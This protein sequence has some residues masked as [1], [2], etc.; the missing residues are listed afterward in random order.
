VI[1]EHVGP[2]VSTPVTAW[3]VQLPV[4]T[5]PL[6]TFDPGISRNICTVAL[7]PLACNTRPKICVP[8]GLVAPASW[9]SG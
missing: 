8:V 5:A 4:P 1:V 6:L 3:F 7:P 2:P 9:H